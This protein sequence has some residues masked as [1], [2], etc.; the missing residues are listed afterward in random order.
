VRLRIV[1]AP[2]SEPVTLAEAKAH[3]RLESTEDDT[4]VSV[5]ILAARQHVE[6]VCW[7]GVVTQTREAVLEAFPYEDA[8]EL[9]GGNL[10]AI[11][12]ATYVDADGVTQTLDGDVY[13]AD[14]VSV[15]GRLVLSYDQTWPSTRSQWDAVR[16]QYT[17]GWAVADVPAPIK[18]AL[19]LLVAHFYEQ[20]NPEITGTIV[21]KVAFAVDALLAPYRLARF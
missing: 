17:V 11:T 10:G 12:S 1:T 13:E 4:Y 20:R 18:Q 15:P 9:P 2:A 8:V 19:L 16:V 7:R 5:L 21:S 6:E 14:T 3:L